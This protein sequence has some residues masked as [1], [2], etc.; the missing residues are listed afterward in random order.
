MIHFLLQFR[1]MCTTLR[2]RKFI[3]QIFEKTFKMTNVTA[4]YL[5]TSRRSILHNQSRVCKL[6]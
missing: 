3:K 6:F 4:R 2:I 1:D 5:M